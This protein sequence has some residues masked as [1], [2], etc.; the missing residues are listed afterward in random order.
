MHAQMWRERLAGE[1]RF[2]QALDELRPALDVREV[3]PELDQLWEEM[4]I[5]RR[6]VAGAT[7]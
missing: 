3:A 1:P 7:W 6:S 5:V 4:T 2:E